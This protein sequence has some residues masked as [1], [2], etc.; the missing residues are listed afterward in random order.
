LRTSRS[1]ISFCLMKKVK[2]RILGIDTVFISLTW[3]VVQ[4]PNWLARNR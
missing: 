2:N 1:N 4:R 3:K